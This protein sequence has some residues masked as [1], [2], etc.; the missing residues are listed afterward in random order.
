MKSKRKALTLAVCAV[1]LVVTTALGTLAYLTDSESVTNTFTVGQVG[2]TLDEAIVDENG[3]ATNDRTNETVNGNAYHL[4]PGLTYD[5]D[6][7]VTV[8]AKSEDCY[9]RMMAT[10]TY[11]EEADAVF[12]KYP[13]GQWLNI[14][15][16]DDGVWKT[17]GIPTTTKADGK[18]SRTYEFRYKEVVEQSE[19]ATK[20]APLF[21]TITVPGGVTNEE[22]ATLQ[23]MV[24]SVEAHA[25][26]AA[27]FNGDADAAWTAFAN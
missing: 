24:I 11:N 3:K 7:T 5:K 6:P 19:T 1:L 21:T 26:Q 8:D 9:V 25:I 10:I 27:G 12:T 13:V 18:I 20:L 17:N 14:D 2:L 22:I 16:T 15:F 4:L 23:G